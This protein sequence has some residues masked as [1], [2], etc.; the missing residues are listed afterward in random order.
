MASGAVFAGAG[1]IDAAVARH[2]RE[3]DLLLQCAR[4]QIDDTRAQRIAE[5]LARGVDGEALIRLAWRH[6]L[7]PLL[8]QS[9]TRAGLHNLAPECQL[10]LRTVA[11][12][13][14][15][16]TLVLCSELLRL[17]RVL[18]AAG[19]VAIPYKGPVL[20]A[21]LYGDA[22]LRQ[23]LDIDLI[24]RPGDAVKARR[25]LMENGCVALK[26]M[27]PRRAAAR[28]WY[29]CDFVFMTAKRVCVDLTWRIA[30]AYWNLPKI[31]PSAWTR[32]GRLS[33]AGDTVPWLAGEDLLVVLCL[34]GSKHKWD[35]LKW[36]VDVAELLRV[37]PQLDWSYLW[38]SARDGGAQR[39]VA[40]GLLLAHDLLQAPVPPAQLER[41]RADA[42][43]APFMAEV[44]RNFSV[45]DAP[46]AS[47]LVELDFLTRLAERAWTRLACRLLR[48]FYF[49]LH[50]MLR[51]AVQALRRHSVRSARDR[52]V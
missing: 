11:E 4:T 37:H 23:I 49:V 21:H 1:E 22:A 3:L 30:P 42:S 9:L 15:F 29:H 12:S 28:A 7:V 16:R 13:S 40:L 6:G 24:V 17:Q 50:H 39:M 44:S 33:L 38:D 26:K 8:Y 41:I 43:L 45:V 48:P 46:S 10:R 51:P 35:T 19:V 47:T 52:P 20:A 27:S 34:H 36:I 25:V 5:D 14:R 31:A 18:T 32:L 2:T